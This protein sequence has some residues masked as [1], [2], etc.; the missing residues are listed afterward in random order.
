MNTCPECGSILDAHEVCHSGHCNSQRM[1]NTV[2][3]IEFESREEVDFSQAFKPPTEWWKAWQFKD[4][5]TPCPTYDVRW[6]TLFMDIAELYAKMSKCS[7]RKV[8]AIIVSDHQILSAGFNGSPAGSNLCQNAGYCPRKRLG[9]K[10][11]EGIELCPAAHGESNAL[12]QAARHGIAVDGATM[13]AWCTLPCK[14]CAGQIINAGIKKVVCLAG[15]S[16]DTLAEL[17]FEQAGVEILYMT[18]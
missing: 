9:Y 10:S 2:G 12:V 1:R 11:G 16:Y 3:S 13:Y 15:E 6:D 18:L 14:A 8:G 17:L 7:S 5:T 4:A